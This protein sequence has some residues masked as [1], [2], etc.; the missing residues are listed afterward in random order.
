VRGRTP[1]RLTVGVFI[2][3][4]I[5]TML[6][7]RHAYWKALEP[8]LIII[9]SCVSVF[10]VGL[11]LKSSRWWPL[12]A[13]AFNIL[14]VFMLVISAIDPKIR[15]YAYF[16]GEEMWDYLVL[17]ALLFGALIEGRRELAAPPIYAASSPSAR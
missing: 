7:L 15:P 12:W 6:P 13:A 11:S 1:E 8:S 3:A 10:L 14:A 5:A 4:D 2:L 17:M 9:D 16:V